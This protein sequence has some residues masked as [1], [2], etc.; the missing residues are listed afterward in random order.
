MICNKNIIYANQ[1]L[2]NQIY[3]CC[4]YFSKKMHEQTFTRPYFACS[5]NICFLD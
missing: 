1:E 3:I 4:G 2:K 5:L